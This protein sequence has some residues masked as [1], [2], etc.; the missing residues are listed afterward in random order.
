MPERCEML[1]SGALPAPKTASSMMKKRLL[2]HKERDKS[3][4]WGKGM[5][6]QGSGRLWS[7]QL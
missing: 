2:H 4:G 6:L 1:Q 3:D 5:F 7:S